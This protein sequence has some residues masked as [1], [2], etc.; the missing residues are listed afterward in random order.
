VQLLR[1]GRET[2]VP[3]DVNY[4]QHIPLTEEQRVA[5]FILATLIYYSALGLFHAEPIHSSAEKT[6]LVE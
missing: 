6:S 3:N 4:L 2:E 1:Q 5:N